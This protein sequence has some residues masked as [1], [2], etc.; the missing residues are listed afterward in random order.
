M[1]VYPSAFNQCVLYCN[2][3]SKENYNLLYFESTF[4]SIYIQLNFKQQIYDNGGSIF[5]CDYVLAKDGGFPFLVVNEIIKLC[6]HDSNVG[7]NTTGTKETPNK[8]QFIHK[9]IYDTQY[10]DI[11]DPLNE[12]RLKS[13]I[14]FHVNDIH[15][16]FTNIL[17]NYYGL[18]H[19]VE[20]VDDSSTFEFYSST[21]STSTYFN[22]QI[23][24]FI[25]RKTTFPDVY[26]IFTNGIHKIQGN[27]IAYI[28]NLQVS[29]ILNTLF[30]NK[31][32]IKLKCQF[33]SERKK[34]KP[35]VT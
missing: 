7:K 23:E 10:I 13:P 11:H 6:G 19:G 29:Q 16:V 17:P 12:Y 8:I 35:I 4:D 20:F 14:L 9:I 5:Y 15:E 22:N 3:N 30:K 21:N 24:S 31:H 25:L 27:N 32:S 1:F 26:E 28:Q 33:C 2:K 34:W 18:V